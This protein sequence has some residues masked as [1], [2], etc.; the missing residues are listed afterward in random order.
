MIST[1]A[2]LK[3][4]ITLLSL[5][6]VLTLIM[7]GYLGA[8]ELNTFS[9]LFGFGGFMVLKVVTSSVAIYT[10]YKYCLPSAPLSTRSGTVVMLV[11]YG[12]VVASNLSL[13]IGA[14]V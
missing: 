6:I 7:V 4:L 11:V 14:V 2:L 9:P 8:T 3:W 5:D 13:S 10:I 1:K 12:V